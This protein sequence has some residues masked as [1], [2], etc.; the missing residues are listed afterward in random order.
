MALEFEF[1]VATIVT[2]SKKTTSNAT[3]SPRGDVAAVS[4][5]P[6]LW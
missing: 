5:C 2:A 6:T 1:D 4:I 3:D